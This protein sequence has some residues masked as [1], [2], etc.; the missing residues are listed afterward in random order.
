LFDLNSL[1]CGVQLFDRLKAETL[2]LAGSHNEANQDQAS[3]VLDFRNTVNLFSLAN[4]VLMREAGNDPK[5]VVQCRGYATEPGAVAPPEIM[6]ALQDGIR[7]EKLLTTL[8]RTLV[9]CLETDGFRM[10]FVDGSPMA[11]GYEISCV[12]QAQYL[13]QSMNKEFAI[14]WLSQS[15][16]E[17]FRPQ[18]AY[19]LQV[20]LQGLRIPVASDDLKT[21]LKSR[22]TSGSKTTI[23]PELKEVLDHYVA[24]MDIV[25]LQKAVKG[26]PDY[27]FSALV[28]RN[29]RQ[30]LLLISERGSALPVV[31]NLRPR[32]T[33]LNGGALSESERI[34]LFLAS[35][36][37]WL[38]WHL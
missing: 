4:Q 25:S 17:A 11:A 29:T 9:D 20:Q 38:E 7:D 10:Q 5:M 1:E 37:P 21:W 31:L 16:R 35:R 8:G 13:D 12:P 23:P 2:V 32:Q 3:D 27:E 36:S 15:L 19:P 6:I 28:D 26:W 34:D 14:L 24:T 33:Q 22:L 18:D 30:L